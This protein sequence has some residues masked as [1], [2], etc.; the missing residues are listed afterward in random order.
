MIS[1]C[2]FLFNVVDS[3]VSLLHPHVLFFKARFSEACLFSVLEPSSFFPFPF[4]DSPDL[5]HAIWWAKCSRSISF[6]VVHSTELRLTHQASQPKI[7]SIS[8]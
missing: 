4:F 2:L 7:I 6:H 8:G 5:N 1:Y 3:V